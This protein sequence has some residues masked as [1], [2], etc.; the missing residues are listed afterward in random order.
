VISAIDF[1]DQ[2][3]QRGI[4]GGFEDVT[5]QWGF[6]VR[7]HGMGVGLGDLDGD[8]QTDA[9]ISTI[10]GVI[11]CA[12]QGA[13][14]VCRGDP[15]GVNPHPWGIYPW[16]ILIDDLNN[17]GWPDVFMVN[18]F[19]TTDRDIITWL[20]SLGQGDFGNGT[21]GSIG[22]D[23]YHFALIGGP[24]GFEAARVP[25]TAIPESQPD[26]GTLNLALADLDDDGVSE[27]IIPTS[28][29]S[30]QPYRLA[31]GHLT[32]LPPAGNG[33]T[34]RPARPT[35]GTRITVHCDGRDHV[36]ELYG[37]E[38][39]A[40]GPRREAHVGCGQAATF[41]SMHIESDG[42]AIDIPAGNTG[43]VYHVP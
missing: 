20:R 43:D 35:P 15:L 32:G 38:G 25:F 7:G 16:G 22:T 12:R 27:V 37:G 31:I 21:P 30:L 19:A 13:T 5:A 17:D 8:G 11:G 40:A 23:P 6:D 33:V 39:Y 29:G 34:I 28:E 14:F 9:V 24:S 2:A 36:V 42:G 41:D 26:Q 4:A 3:A 1:H 10:A 18:A